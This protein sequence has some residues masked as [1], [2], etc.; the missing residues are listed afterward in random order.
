MLSIWRQCVF[1]PGGTYVAR[2]ETAES[3]VAQSGVALLVQEIFKVLLSDL[4]PLQLTK[5]SFCV[6]VS[7]VFLTSRLSTA[8]SRERPMSHSM[9]R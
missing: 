3:T 5:P 7:Y 2:S 4:L 6:A 1:F 8:L 9:E